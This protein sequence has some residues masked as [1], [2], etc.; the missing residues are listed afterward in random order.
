M[1]GI[2]IGEDNDLRVQVKKD[3]NGLITQ[4][5]VVGDIDYQRVKLIVEAHKGEFKEAPTLGF[6]IDRFLKAVGSGKRQQFVAELQRELKS[7][8]INSAKIDVGDN[9]M[10]FSVD[11]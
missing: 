5:F 2:L 6:G 1:K 3:S 7:D 9:L 4:G 8:G 11:L 10:K